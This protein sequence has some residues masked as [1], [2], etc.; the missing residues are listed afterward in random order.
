MAHGCRFPHEA[1]STCE[2]DLEAFADAIVGP[3]HPEPETLGPPCCY[4]PNLCGGPH[5]HCAEALGGHEDAEHVA[6]KPLYSGPHGDYTVHAVGDCV[7]C[8]KPL[9]YGDERDR[10]RPDS[11]AGTGDIVVHISERRRCC[12]TDG[13]R[14]DCR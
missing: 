1:C 8:D 3:P 13:C 5:E 2:R 4:T 10:G 6:V 14:T 7:D 11:R 9:T 12:R